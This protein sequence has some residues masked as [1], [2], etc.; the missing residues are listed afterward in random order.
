[1]GLIAEDNERSI[2][3]NERMSGFGRKGT[4]QLCYGVSRT[5]DRKGSNDVSTAV[6]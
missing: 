1:M 6:V 3:W 5:K 4:A 2:C